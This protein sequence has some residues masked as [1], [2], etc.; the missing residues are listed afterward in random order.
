VNG[1]DVVVAP[2]ES[3]VLEDIKVVLGTM[4]K[5]FCKIGTEA[6]FRVFDV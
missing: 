3:A 5:L 2:L 1:I 4:S 6:E